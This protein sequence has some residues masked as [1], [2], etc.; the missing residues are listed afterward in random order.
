MEKILPEDVSV[1]VDFSGK[2]IGAFT[3]KPTI[4]V[5]GEAYAKVGAVGTYSVSATLREAPPKETE[6]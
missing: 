3:I 1:I 4:T 2:E 6:G 5:R